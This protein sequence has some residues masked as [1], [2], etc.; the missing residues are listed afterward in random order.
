MK[1]S[2]FLLRPTG[3]SGFLSQTFRATRPD[4]RKSYILKV[5]SP[6]PVARGFSRKIQSFRRECAA[7]R[8]LRPIHGQVTPRCMASFSNPDG[9]DGLLWL[10]EITPARTGDQ[11]AGL[12]WGELAA[13][14]RSIGTVHARFWNARKLS[15][16]HRLPFHR[17][18]RA[19]ETKAHLRTFQ[20]DCR[21]L[22]RSTEQSILPLAG[23]AISRALLQCKTR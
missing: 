5:G 23:V 1:S 17:Y 7:Y 2:R 22:L 18:N 21:S 15:K 16:I 10:Q 13:A 8:L 4:D 6:D 3:T 20:K 19:H 11:I 12:T 9:S 14:A